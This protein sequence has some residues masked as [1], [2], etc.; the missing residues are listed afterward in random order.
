MPK[1]LDFTTGETVHQIAVEKN[2]G[3]KTPDEI[4]TIFRRSLANDL[5]RRLEYAKHEKMFLDG[6]QLRENDY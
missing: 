4:F 2:P 6:T 5:V 3:Q 1:A